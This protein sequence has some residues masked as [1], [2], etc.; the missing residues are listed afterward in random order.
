MRTAAASA[1]RVDEVGEAIGQILG[2]KGATRFE[3]YT[4]A[5]ASGKKVLRD[6]FSRRATPG[7]APAI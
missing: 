6:V 5:A 3:G 2:S 4:D 1:A 7:T